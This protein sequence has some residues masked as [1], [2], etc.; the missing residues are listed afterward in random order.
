MQI[1]FIQFFG[2]IIEPEKNTEQKTDRQ[3]TNG[4]LQV[5]LLARDA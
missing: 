1:L 2:W 4:C 5:R 3:N